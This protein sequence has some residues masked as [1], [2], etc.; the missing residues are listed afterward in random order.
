MRL[1]RSWRVLGLVLALTCVSPVLQVPFRSVATAAASPPPP[2]RTGDPDTPEWTN[3][4]VGPLR[5]AET[6]V[7][8]TPSTTW[9]ELVL[10]FLRGAR[11]AV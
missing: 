5:P 11:V 4:T 1:E 7:A 3:R 6:S 2:R 8:T 10:R 9:R